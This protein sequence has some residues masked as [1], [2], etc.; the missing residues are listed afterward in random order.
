[1]QKRLEPFP[2]DL[3]RQLPRLPA[4]YRRGVIGAD[5][6]ILDSRT[7]RIIDIIHDIYDLARH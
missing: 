2:Q 3:E 7:Q 5:V 6:V 4:S 1:L